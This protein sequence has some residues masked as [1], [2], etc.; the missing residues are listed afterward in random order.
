MG[1]VVCHMDFR[2]LGPLEVV[3]NGAA[4]DV[5]SAKQRALL[6]VLLLNA[7]RVVSTDAL[8]ESLWGERAPGTAAKALQVYVSQLRKAVGRDRI[9]TRSPGYELRVEPGEL[10]LDVFEQHVADGEFGEALGLWRG[11]PLAEFAY[12]PFAQ[13]EIARLEELELACLERRIDA[14]LAEGEH[15]VLVGEL[16]GS[17]VST[18]FASGYE[19]S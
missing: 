18:R 4:I 9:V 5:G 2:L 17:C 15:A 13:S 16:E 12:E 7:N 19:R 11:G 10:D 1:S 3:E 14:D 6:A 8:I